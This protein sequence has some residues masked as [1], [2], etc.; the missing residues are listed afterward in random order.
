[1]AN[2]LTGDF[3]VV[4][5]FA[6]PA[7]NRVLAAMHRRERFLHSVTLRVDDNPPR[8]SQVV[9]PTVVG[10]VDTFGDPTVDHTRIG[11]PIPLPGQLSAT[12][13]IYSL[14]DPVVNTGL[15]VATEG[16]IVPSHL[17]GRAQL[18]LAPPAIE[19][20]DA[21]GKN[22]TVRLDIMGRYFPDPHT[23]PLAEFVRGELQITAAV[24]QIASPSANVVDINIKA[25]NIYI[26]FT[27]TFSS[28]PLSAEDLAGIN[29]LIR[30]AL[31][32]S[33]LPS[34]AA[35]PP[36]IS[37]MQFK[38]LLGGP[39]AIA[40]L[41]NIQGARGDP[42]SLNDV[43]LGAADDFA[44]AA[45]V[46]Y[47]KRAFQ[48]DLSK[49]YNHWGYT[50]TLKSATIALQQGKITVT[51]AGHAHGNHWYTPSFDFTIHQDFTLKPASMTPGGPLNTVELVP[52][53]IGGGVTGWLLSLFGDNLLDPATQDEVRQMF[54]V[55]AN[56][57][58]FLESLLTPPRPK[59]L[60]LPPQGPG[61]QLAY[62]SV[63]I[64]PSG[65]VLHGSLAVLNPPPGPEI[66]S[67]GIGSQSPVAPVPGWP[68]PQVEFEQVPATSGGGGM[69]GTVGLIPSGP[70]YSALKSWIPGG[71]ILSFEW[72]SQ[73]QSQPFLIDNDKFVLIHPPPEVSTG[74]VVG[75]T[76]LCLTI[77]G[78]RVSASGPMVN[79]D[80]SGTQCGYT[81]VP[82]V[83]GLRVAP[84][85]A[86]PS[87]ALTQPSPGG[88]LEIAGHTAAQVDPTGRNTPNLLVHFA[89][90]HTISHLEVLT[91]ALRESG[92]Q[93]ATTA[94]L[95]VLTPD[96]MAKAGYVQGVT[97]A[98]DQGGAWES[99]FGVKITRRP[100][101][102]I[103]GP[104]GNVMW[105]QAGELDSTTLAAALR[106]SLAAGGFVRLSMLRSNLRIDQ[107]PPNFLFEFVPGRELAL[108]KLAG[109]AVTLVFWKSSSK[110]SIEAVRDLQQGNGKP[111]ARGPVV[112]AIND[113]ESP[114]LA[115]RVATENG[116]SAT[117]VTDPKR[118]ISIAYGVNVWPTIVFIDGSGLVRGIRY[119][120]VAGKLGKSSSGQQAGAS[121]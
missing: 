42:G 69:V 115:R 27:P 74:M 49:T 97:Y 47:V 4:A 82:I 11:N 87:V 65:I 68:P 102:L 66:L 94:V 9:R 61:F 28:Q 104:K 84:T 26:N 91:S 39:N 32:T 95:A 44:F 5:E 52:G 99:L 72:S 101:T 40:V 86:L 105:Q 79:Q 59:L 92:R 117:I 96:Q 78:K 21:S 110:P 1:M 37:Y 53:D 98:E 89:D 24:D 7:A 30:N 118:E 103:V 56:L 22:I 93:D 116:L 88:L 83:N 76:P 100:L 12:N 25:E 45:G 77:R 14:L 90:D 73:G 2:D 112:L 114:D 63:D 75:Y 109:R 15:L 57:G 17:Q 38:T 13:P 71:R 50:I 54:S 113:G 108:R 48:V 33:L 51:V 23:S 36:S 34:N 120:R 67:P 80:V 31:K 41:L 55:D 107:A 64:Q 20:P 119:G 3:D 106:K 18:Q 29:L 6:I 85:G 10:S 70:D 16:T 46:D 58:G 35:L 121:R 81:S 62:T 8:G 19:V 111:A 43:F 60:P